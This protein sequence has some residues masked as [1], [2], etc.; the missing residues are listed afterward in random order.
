MGHHAVNHRTP[1]W[2]TDRLAVY[3]VA[4]PDQTSRDLIDTVAS[5]LSAGATA[6]QLRTKTLPDRETL[7]LALA[8]ATHCRQHDALFIINDRLDLA[9]A[10]GADGIHLGVDDLPL[11]AARRLSPPDFIIG[12]SPE[13]DDQTVAAKSDG[14]NYLGIGPVFGTS[15]K[16][17]AGSAIGLETI[18]RRATL[19]HIPIIGIGGITPTN[20]PSVI[21]TGAVGVAVVSSILRAP[22][23]SAATRDLVEAVSHARVPPLPRKGEGVGG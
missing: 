13:T 9:L 19:A 21:H 23:P 6:I 11:P 18:H 14:A 4:D 2:L 16:S 17:D 3:L 10:S 7:D 20:A 22:D 8:I 5:A 12:Y 15:S 1:D